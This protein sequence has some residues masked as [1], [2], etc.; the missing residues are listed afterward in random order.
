MCIRD[1]TQGLRGLRI[2]CLRIGA[3]EVRAASGPPQA[4]RSSAN[5]DSARNTAQNAPLGSFGGRFRGRSWAR[6][7]PGSND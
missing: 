3:R 4:P 7:V 2:G 5:S 1:S 6:A